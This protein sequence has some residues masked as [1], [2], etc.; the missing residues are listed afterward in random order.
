MPSGLAAVL[1]PDDGARTAQL[2]GVTEQGNLEGGKNVLAVAHVPTAEE[3]EPLRVRPQLYAA[4]ARRVPS[5]QV[6]LRHEER[7]EPAT[8]LARDRPAVS[9]VAIAYVCVRGACQLPTQDPAQLA[10]L[11]G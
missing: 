10:A 6:L 3:R 8:P 5:S 9:G 7:A 2:F 4:R 11:L 1:G